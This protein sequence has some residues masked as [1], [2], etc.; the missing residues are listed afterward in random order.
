MAI[1]RKNK[2]DGKSLLRQTSPSLLDMGIDS[3][4]DRTTI[5]ARIKRYLC[6]GCM[7]SGAFMQPCPS[8]IAPV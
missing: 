8:E 4:S 1:F 7:T 5:L 3:L 6:L 2:I